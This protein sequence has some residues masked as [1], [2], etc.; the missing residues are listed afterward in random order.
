[1]TSEFKATLLREKFILHDPD[2]DLGGEPPVVALSNRLVLSLV[3]ELGE[4]PETY[5]IRTQNMHSCVRLA[6]AVAKEYIDRGAIIGRIMEFRWDRLWHDVI[7]GYEKDWNPNI[8]AAIY[9][10]GRIVFEEGPRH[11][12]LDIIEKC[13]AVSGSDYTKSV[14]FAEQAFQQ[15]SGKAMRIEHDSNI[16]FIM[17]MPEDEPIRCAIMLRGNS[18][19]TTFSYQVKPKKEGAEKPR[20]PTL[21]S[22]AA[23]FMEGVNL[24]FQVGM[25]NRKME[26]GLMEKYSDEERKARR[27]SERVINLGGAIQTFENK[28]SVHYR[29]ESPDFQKIIAEAESFASGILQPKVEDGAKKDEPDPQEQLIS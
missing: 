9:Y 16:A 13:D 25:S 1:M 15:A 7:K 8:W 5:V 3:H 27:S 18:R 23:A 6:A 17:N 21:L 10:K 24:A 22:I 20:I 19:K 11:P 4:P 26:L 29:P 28:F 2:E 14:Q 12:F